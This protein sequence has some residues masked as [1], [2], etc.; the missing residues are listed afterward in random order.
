M[1]VSRNWLQ[2]YF[3]KEIPT[4][5]KLDELFT[6]H[7]FEVEGVETLTGPGIAKPDSI[8][9][10]KILPDR[11]HYDLCHNGIAR[12]ISVLTGLP[13]KNRF[14]EELKVTSKEKPSVKIIS[15]GEAFGSLASGKQFCRR[16]TARTIELGSSKAVGTSPVWLKNALESIGQRSINSIVD[17][18]N[19]VMYDIGQPLHAFDADKVKGGIT[20][21]PAKDSEKITLLDGREI[22]LTSVDN[23]IADEEGPLVIAGAKGGRRAEIGESTKKIIIESANF[24]PTMVRRTATKYD[25]RSDSSKRFENEITAELAMNGMNN[26]SALILEMIPDAKFGPVVDG[27]PVEQT[28]TVIDFDPAYLKE[29]LGVDVPL[30]EAKSILERMGIVVSV[31]PAKAGIQDMT[32]ESVSSGNTLDSRRSLSSERTVNDT[33]QWILTIPFERLDLII[34]EDIVEEVG[35]VY[36]YDKVKGILP[37][38]QKDESNKKV[39]EILPLFYVSEKIKSTLVELGFSEVSLYALVEK[40]DIEIAKPLAKDKGFARNNLSGGMMACVEKNALNADLLGLEVVKVFEVG[41][42]FTDKSEQVHLSIGVAQIKKVKGLKAENIITEAIKKI[43]EKLMVSIS[44]KTVNGKTGNY[45]V[46]EIDLESIVKSFQ[47]PILFEAL[48]FTPAS[49]NRYKK[50]SLYPFIVRDVAVFVPESVESEKVWNVI[51]KGIAEAGANDLLARH[52]LFD[53]FKK[54]GKVSY[55]FRMIFQSKERTLT[56]EEVNKTMEVIYSGLKGEGWEVR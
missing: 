10:V 12:E 8:L 14:A 33:E 23:V 32:K 47:S 35:R 7:A 49:T 6:F 36:G 52:S 22:I 30:D 27:Y 16:Y 13:M 54:E 37:P 5:E 42:V 21:R 48:N 56:D 53:T 4:A 15:G 11:A 20:I 3:D 46:F 26:V 39:S 43:E 51:E 34:K 31:I 44:G 55:A 18:T 50:F 24:D 17:I 9:D 1:K 38:L 2:T 19:Y 40:G 25:I 45:S 29:R 28:P 41:H